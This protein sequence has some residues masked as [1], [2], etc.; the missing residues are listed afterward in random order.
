MK[1]QFCGASSGV[2]GSCH[3][4][5]SGNHQV[6]LD[7]G[8]FQGGKA[9]DAM[10]YEPFPFNP[11]E[12][13]C[14]VLSHA[15]IDHCGRLPLLVKRGFSGP[16][17][18]T[19]ATADL[20]DIML[21][22]SAYIHEKDAEDLNRKGKRAGNAM[23]EPLYTLQDALDTLKLIRPVIYDQLVH[24]NDDM[25]IVFNDAGH[26]L[27][28]AIIEIWVNEDGKEAKIVFSGDLGMTD[29]P[30]LRDPTYI[31]KADFVI[32]ESTYGNRNHVENG[33]S[34]KDLLDIVINTTKRGG[35]VIIPSFAVGRTQEIIFEF[36]KFFAENSEYK[37]QLDKIKIYVDS[38]MAGA[39]T[40][41]FKRNAQVFDEESRDFLLHGD[42]PLDFPNLVFTRSSD[43]SRQLNFNTEPKV[44]I[45][46]SGM[47]EAGRIRHHLKHNLWNSRNSIVFVGYQAVGTLGRA[48][49]DGQDKVTLFGE[50]I[51]VKAEIHNLEGFSGH[52]DQ[53]GLFTWAAHFQKRPK[54]I[55]LVH[56]E[57]ESKK[58]FA[59]LLNEKLGYEPVVVMGNSEYE[60][61]ME[62]QA[63]LNYQEA[64]RQ[65]AAF[66]DVQNVRNQI[67][68]IHTELEHILYNTNLA[69][70]GDLSTEKIVK[71]NNVIQ[72]LQKAT[73]NLGSI[74]TGRDLPL[75]DAALEPDE[76]GNKPVKE[77]EGN[78]AGTIN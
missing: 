20:L 14:V 7:C 51:S 45:S 62:G 49:I 17:Y 59:D 48:L 64:Q 72:E 60:L 34:I 27:G 57:E 41:I 75:G 19:D 12:I 77:K 35:N 8:Q 55:F 50:E 18:C 63:I 37:E 39:A 43:E 78:L 74:V 71:I 21:K 38:P 40:E 1:I 44:I 10:N 76:E 3:L 2:T 68:N 52:A 33:A 61:D 58:V 26:I 23:V 47:C 32:M 11:A 9:Q 67:S 28:S 53:N 30:I 70:K 46:A 13:E 54:Q 29:R 69:L 65:A 25:R 15:H 31:K 24:I 56:G 6:L 66:E 22:D 73:L 5:K 42:N 16:I 4:L 36:N